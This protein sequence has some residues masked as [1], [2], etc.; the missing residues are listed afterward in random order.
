VPELVHELFQE[1]VQRAP[2][3]V[4]AVYEGD[5]LTYAEL[6]AKANQLAHHLRK[7]RIGPDQLVGLCVERSLDMVVALLGILKAGGAYVPLDPSY[8]PERLQHII[9]DAC[10]RV[11]LTQAHLA[12]RLPCSNADVITLDEQ[13]SEIARRLD[14]NPDAGVLGLTPQNLA[15]VIYTSGS[16]GKPKGVMIEH[17]H[18]LDLWQG[19]EGAYRHSSLCERVA[20][21]ASLNFDASVQQIVQLLS[22]RSLF[23]ISEKCRRD[24]SLLFRFFVESQ[25]HAVD[26]TPSQLK[27]WLS[28][29]LL[30]ADGCSLRLVL[31]GG[32]AVD[33]E[34]WDI[35]AACSGIDFYNVYGPTECT[36]DSTIAHLKGDTTAPHIGLPMKNRRIYVLEPDHHPT[37]I[38]VTGEIHIGGAGIGRGYLNR[39]ELT[40]ERFLTDPF[41]TDPQARM[42][43]TGDLGRW[44]TDGNIEYLGRNDTQVKVRGFRIELGEI[45]SQLLR[46]PQVKEAVVLA[47]EDI[48]GE[49][50]LVAYVVFRDPPTVTKALRVE[51]LLEHLRPALPQYMLPSAFVV[52]E[53][54]P[55]TA[56][57]KL[58][59]RALPAPQ[60]RSEEMCTYIAPR[61]E[62][63]RTLADIWTQVLKVDPIGVHDTLLELGGDS[64]HAM[65]LI[66]R[67]AAE[68]KVD[69]S[70]VEVLQSPTIEQLTQLIEY[71]RLS[72]A[73]TLIT[74]DSE[75]EEGVV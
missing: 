57:G 38:G 22:G 2:G 64:L 36:V 52:L 24:A 12:G 75:Y 69:V 73:E 29:G 48:P 15:Y 60:G 6:N 27:A 67:I 45:E 5:S 7:R 61:T 70:V 53:S 50:R 21:N 55:M 44:R 51:A 18:I 17:R 23:V 72:E 39:P 54:F 47:R 20:L 26:C 19:L 28:T 3:A 62:I 34:L 4:A 13:W 42:Y 58:D 14:H 25:I 65:K 43:K 31:V 8:P 46:H 11:L 66:T 35:L 59:R 63:E 68:F 30:E 74:G 32:E 10:P 37:P 41:S 56:N 16:T 40:A 33:D 71:K 9:S 49:K 1:Q